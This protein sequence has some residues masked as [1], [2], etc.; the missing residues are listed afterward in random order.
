MDVHFCPQCTKILSLGRHGDYFAYLGLPRKLAVD[1]AED[2]SSGSGRSAASFIRTTSTM[3]RRR[4]VAR[5]SNGR[6]I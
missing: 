4:N 3:R 6:R 2:S 1:P 5:A